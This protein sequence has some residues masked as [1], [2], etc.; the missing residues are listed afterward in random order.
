MENPCACEVTLLQ[1]QPQ[2]LC[3]GELSKRFS[4][5]ARRNNASFLG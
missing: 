3:P 2:Q 1:T 5:Q 4:F